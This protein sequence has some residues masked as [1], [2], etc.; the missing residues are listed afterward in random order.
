MNLN[1]YIKRIGRYI[2][3]KYTGKFEVRRLKVSIGR[4][5]INSIKKKVWRNK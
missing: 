3:R 2:E 5:V 4:R 1:I